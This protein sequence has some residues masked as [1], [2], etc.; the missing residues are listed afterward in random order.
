MK[1]DPGRTLEFLPPGIP[2]C[3]TQ[4]GC[5]RHAY[6]VGVPDFSHRYNEIESKLPEDRAGALLIHIV[7]HVDRRQTHV[8]CDWIART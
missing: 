1:G 3:H 2:L 8:N 4:I 7:A 6:I 5:P